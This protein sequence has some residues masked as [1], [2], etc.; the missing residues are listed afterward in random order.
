MFCGNLVYFKVILLSSSKENLATLVCMKHQQ[1]KHPY[2]SVINV[3]THDM[4]MDYFTVRIHIICGLKTSW[5]N[6]YVCSCKL[7]FAKVSFFKNSFFRD[8]GWDKNFTVCAAA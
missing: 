6:H 5:P 8:Y 1:T 3:C 7:L 4:K 2:N